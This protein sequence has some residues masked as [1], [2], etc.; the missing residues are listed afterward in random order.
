M[1]NRLWVEPGDFIKVIGNAG[2]P[3]AAGLFVVVFN[4]A[5]G[6][7]DLIRAHSGVANKDHFIVTGEL[8]DQR[9]GVDDVGMA[10]LVFLPYVFV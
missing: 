3:C 1:F 2:Q 9:H 5:A 4:R 10:A 8:V 7:G 6:V